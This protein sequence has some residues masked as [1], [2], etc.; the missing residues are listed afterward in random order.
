MT[1]TRIRFWPD[2]QVFT[3]D[4]DWSFEALVQRARQ[5]AY[6]V[7]G[8]A[9]RVRDERPAMGQRPAI[10]PGMTR[11]ARGTSPDQV[12]LRK[13][14]RSSGSTAESASSARTCRPGSR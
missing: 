3:K 11:R 14:K 9:I 5:T 12:P 13:K 7:P 10:P 8:L 4:A 6:L 1:G 2:R